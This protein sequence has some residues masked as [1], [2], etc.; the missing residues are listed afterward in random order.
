LLLLVFA[1][2]VHSVFDFFIIWKL[3]KN[4][5]ITGL[6]SKSKKMNLSSIGKKR[7]R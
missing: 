3:Y 1:V 7:L 4:K 6:N 5:N 2:L